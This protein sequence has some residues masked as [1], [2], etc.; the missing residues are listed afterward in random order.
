MG[1]AESRSTVY[2]LNENIVINKSDMNL[3]DKTVNEI[4]SN[5]IIK[6]ANHISNFRCIPF[7]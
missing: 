3:V 5:T 1:G 2:Q 6:H 4:I 7:I